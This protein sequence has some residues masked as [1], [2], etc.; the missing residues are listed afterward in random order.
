MKLLTISIKGKP[1]TWS[2]F[3]VV[4]TL[5][6]IETKNAIRSPQIY[7]TLFQ[8][9]FYASAHIEIA[10]KPRDT[11]TTLKRMIRVKVLK[12]RL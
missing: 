10:Y 11:T 4:Y 12:I 3:G 7:P 8:I 2:N 6:R 5:H 9:R 1:S